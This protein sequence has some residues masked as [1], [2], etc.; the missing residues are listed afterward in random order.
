[1]QTAPHSRNWRRLEGGA[2][3]RQACTSLQVSAFP[4]SALPKHLGKND[5]SNRSSLE[6]KQAGH[7]VPPRGQSRRCSVRC[8]QYSALSGSVPGRERALTL[9]AGL[10]TGPL[11]GTSQAFVQGSALF[12][13]LT[14]TRRPLTPVFP[15]KPPWLAVGDGT[16]AVIHGVRCEGESSFT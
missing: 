13:Q 2:W 10:C 6:Q 5:R 15:G 14:F 12:L 3:P 1:M 7:T 8:T 9:P 16:Q 4:T 11:G